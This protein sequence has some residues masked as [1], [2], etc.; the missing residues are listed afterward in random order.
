MSLDIIPIG[1]A[2]L[3][4]ASTPL[5]M[6]RHGAVS[7]AIKSGCGSTRPFRGETMGILNRRTRH[8]V[9]EISS[10][11]GLI[12]IYALCRARGEGGKPDPKLEALL[13]HHAQKLKE[14]QEMA[15]LVSSATAKQTTSLLHATMN[16]S[17]QE[18]LSK[19][20]LRLRK[21][22]SWSWERMSRE[23]HRVMGQEGPSNTT[24]FRYA[25][26][27]GKRPNVVTER[28]VQQAI[29]KVTVELSQKEKQN[30]QA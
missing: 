23:F 19:Q 6:H 26:G 22:T 27:K 8:G 2:V 17:E 21:K 20:L 13:A 30:R 24:L 4:E 15:K 28:Y 16:K 10:G 25:K 9:F 1:D 5:N 29:D 14:K 3:N 12:S 11:N 18:T 7:L